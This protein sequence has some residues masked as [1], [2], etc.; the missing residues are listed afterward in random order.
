MLPGVDRQVFIVEVVGRK[1]EPARKQALTHLHKTIR[2]QHEPEGAGA[3]MPRNQAQIKT[4]RG[5]SMAPS[6]FAFSLD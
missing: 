6:A 3:F 4:P 5:A 1:G 2:A